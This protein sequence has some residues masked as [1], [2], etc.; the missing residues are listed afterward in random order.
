[1]TADHLLRLGIHHEL[2]QH[3]LVA[4]RQRRLHRPEAR[5]VDVDLA[6]ALGRRVLGQSDRADLRRREHPRRNE[7]VVDH[8]CL[9]AEHAVG[10]GMPLA[11]RD[12]RQVHAV[13]HVADRVDARHIGA[14]PGIHLDLTLLAERHTG[15]LQSDAGRVGRAADRKHDLV[16][17]H[18]LPIRQMP[19]QP[20]RSFS[21]FVKTLPVMMRMPR[22]AYSCVSP[23]RRSSSKPRRI[24]SRAVD[25]RRLGAEPCEDAGE[26]H[27]DVAAAGDDD[28]LAAAASDGTPRWR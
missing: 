23:S 11:D 26:L 9:L 5:L 17:R 15:R 21:I 18:R 1:M 13:G 27:R 20:V 3:P 10:E 6:V 14:R 22:R 19:G 16:G 12:R 4:P 24:L 28:A 25:Q 7:I 8:P 2:H